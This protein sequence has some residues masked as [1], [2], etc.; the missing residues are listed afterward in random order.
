MRIAMR[1]GEAFERDSATDRR[2]FGQE[3]DAIFTMRFEIVD[4]HAVW[5]ISRLHTAT[6]L[7]VMGLPLLHPAVLAK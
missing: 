7:Y 6:C 5:N 4:Y 3:E 1:I 2:P